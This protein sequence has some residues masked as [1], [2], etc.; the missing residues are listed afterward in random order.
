MVSAVVFAA[1]NSEKLAEQNSLLP[2]GGK[3]ALQWVLEGALASDLREVI[4]V[5]RDLNATRRHI[6][7]TDDRLFWLVNYGADGAQSS[8]L[9]AG[10]WAIDPNSDGALLLAGEQAF[11]RGD[12]IDALI[13]RFENSAALIVAPT[14]RG[15]TRNP[16][17]VRRDLFPELLK[18]TGEQGGRALIEKYRE[19]TELIPWQDEAPFREIDARALQGREKEPA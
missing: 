18:L 14:H 15:Q 1:G 13:E 11:V 9:G 5:V 6:S 10:L 17:L 8:S 2:L 12:L 7:L 3:P 19:Q 4:C 16:V